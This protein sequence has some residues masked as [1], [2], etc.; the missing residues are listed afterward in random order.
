MISLWYQFICPQHHSFHHF[1]IETLWTVT[2]TR[3]G[4]YPPA[5]TA[6][7][8]AGHFWATSE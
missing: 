1:V 6:A 8:E 2:N 3:L 7:T 4:L 5:H